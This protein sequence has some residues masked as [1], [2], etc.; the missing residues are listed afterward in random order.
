[1]TPFQHWLLKEANIAGYGPHLEP[2]LRLA[3]EA[4]RSS[5]L[6]LMNDV[7]ADDPDVI[8]LEPICCANPIDGRQWC[9]DDVFAECENNIRS[10]RY[11]RADL[12]RRQI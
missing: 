3:F 8:Y 4:G 9:E 1:M 7:V 2:A 5:L 12:Y 10:T 6:N 11:I